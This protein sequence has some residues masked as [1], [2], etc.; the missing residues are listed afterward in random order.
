MG[1]L[2]LLLSQVFACHASVIERGFVQKLPTF[3]KMKITKQKRARLRALIEEATVD[4]YGGHRPP[5]T[6]ISKNY[7]HTK[8]SFP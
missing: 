4:R 6:G 3:Y 1:Y 5:S 8:D 7:P 2:Q